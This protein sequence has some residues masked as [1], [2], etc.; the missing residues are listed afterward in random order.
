MTG[1]MQGVAIAQETESTPSSSDSADDELVTSTGTAEDLRIPAR[2][3]VGHTSSG[4]GFDGTTHIRGFIPL[5]QQSG[6]NI[7]YIAPQFLI[8]N[9]GDVGG[10]LLVGHRVYSESS[11][12]IWGG[13]LSFD[14]RETDESDFYQLGLGFE[15]LG[16]VWDF[17]VNGYVPLGDTSQVTEERT[18]DTGLD[19]SSGF[20]GNLLVLSSRRER[21]SIRIEDIALSGFDAEVG[22]RLARWN[23]GNGDLRGFAGFYFYDATRVDSTLGWRV[24]LEVRPVQNIILGV[25]AQ[26]DEIFGNNIVGSI[27]FEFPRTRPK[28][29]VSD[30]L[31]MIARLGES[32]RRTSSIAVE[33]QESRE[34]LIEETE[35]PLMNPE[36]ER[37]YRF[38]HVTLGRS[39]NGDGTVESPFGTVEE[40]IADSISD[41]NNII[42]V[43]AGSNPD[44]PAFTIPDR[45][46]VLSQGPTQFIA[47]MP[48]PGFP[49][50]SSR[51]PFSAV[52]N[53]DEGVLVELPFSGDG[54]FPTIR[55]SSATNLVTLGNRTVLSGFQLADAPENAIIGRS[56]EDVEIRDNTITNPGERGIY[57]SDVTGSAI[58]FD[59]AI[60]GAQGDA[61]SGQGLLI[62]NTVNGSLDAVVQRHQI[63]NN[64]V[65]IEIRT[66]GDGSDLD[67]ALQLVSIE[68]TSVSDN[69]E[70]GIV[71]IADDQGSQILSF[72]DGE[73]ENNGADGLQVSGFNSAAQEFSISG[74]TIA[75]NDGHGLR[76]QAGVTDGTTTTA[77]EI[78]IVD[79]TI[80]N[81]A[82]DGISVE[83]NEV[84]AQ[85]IA[86]TNNIITNNGGAGIRGI[87]NN[88]SFQEYVTEPGNDTFGIRG[89]TISNNGDIGIQLIGNNRSTL[90]ADI[91]NNE[92]SGNGNGA[93]EVTIEATANT[94][95]VCTVLNGNV[96]ST[97]IQLDNNSSSTTIALFEVGNLTTLATR[98]IGGITLLPDT[99]A[100]TDLGDVSSCF[101]S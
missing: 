73:I 2:G 69:T 71:A 91:A 7:T 44:I 68:E 80:S 27:A 74:S 101:D 99:S 1:L 90:V 30:E 66:M 13:Y 86:I 65:G 82:N 56:I 47:G 67:N 55:D 6:R 16:D 25:N 41:G 4:A 21:Q 61:S 50:Q 26:G 98:N 96:S 45:V 31:E 18:F 81:N 51:L 83:S 48:F 76:F 84:V 63:E 17:R 85:E 19:V 77:Q 100:F 38:I 57:L 52:V 97:G 28:R 79:N 39:A 20:Q 35:E 43:D 78:F 75:G 10:N 95:D 22:A 89:N 49:E 64:R 23:E 12:R 94:V 93:P 8:D 29:P 32:V 33:T 88:L 11:D 37:P 15:S 9:A 62:E 58:F 92:F 40:A 42:Y 5:R 36:E 53:F 54:N 3:G 59:N 24:G 70:E 14:A 46:T 34:T 87:A 60:S 72:T